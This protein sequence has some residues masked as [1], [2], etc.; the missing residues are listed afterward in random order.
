MPRHPP[1]LLIPALALI[2]LIVL[3]PS[4]A[5]ALPLGATLRSAAESPEAT[6]GL[7]SRLWGFLTAIW[8]N[9]SILD[10]NGT[11]A[12]SG[13]DPTTATTDNGSGL[14]PDGRP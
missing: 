11:N 14:E 10:P 3:S 6:P 8:E 7:F 1:R 5:T 9:G 13:P 12:A 2:T 4:L